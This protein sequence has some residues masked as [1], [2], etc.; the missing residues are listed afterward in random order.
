MFFISDLNAKIQ[1]KDSEVASVQS[2]L[3]TVKTETQGKFVMYLYLLGLPVNQCIE[4]CC[5]ESCRN[6]LTYYDY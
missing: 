6:K 3:E 5:H 2:S 4:L 1:S